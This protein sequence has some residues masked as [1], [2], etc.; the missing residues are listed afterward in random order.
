MKKLR[1]KPHREDQ[2]KA[3]GR[4]ELATARHG[5]AIL[6]AALRQVAEA[7][8]LP[9]GQVN[10]KG[11]SQARP[12]L[13]SLH[14]NRGLLEHG[15][16]GPGGGLRLEGASSLWSAVH[17]PSEVNPPAGLHERPACGRLKEALPPLA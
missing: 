1:Q 16:E 13:P 4:Q 12:W 7:G 8:K 3:G 5:P 9:P 10:S 6:G 14:L 15:E 11:A 2:A 17:C